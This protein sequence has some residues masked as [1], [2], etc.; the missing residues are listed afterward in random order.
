MPPRASRLKSAEV[1]AEDIGA[2]VAVTL[3]AA[4]LA[5]A[6]AAVGVT[7]VTEAGI[8]LRRFIGVAERS[9]LITDREGSAGHR[10]IGKRLRGRSLLRPPSQISLLIKV[11]PFEQFGSAVNL[12]QN[13]SHSSTLP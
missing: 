5:A 7:S 4:A 6:F 11:L 10:D 9:G 3:E 12:K 13:G 1:V 8:M 2:A